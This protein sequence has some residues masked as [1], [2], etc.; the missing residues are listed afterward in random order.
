M[1]NIMKVK[2][3]F[4]YTVA[5]WLLVSLTLSSCSQNIAKQNSVKTGIIDANNPYI[6]YI[7]RFD[8]RN[9]KKVAFDWPG[10]YIYAKFQG[11]SCALRLKD[12]TNEYSI[13]IDN[14]APKLLTTGKKDVYK[15]ASGLSDSVAH[16]IMIQKRTEAFVG[17][18]VFMGFILD[19]GDS[20]LPPG[21]RPVRRIEFIG[22]SMTCGYGVLGSSPACHFSK[23]TED[24]GMSY[25][26][27]VARKLHADYHLVS[28][29]GKGV[30]RNYGDKNKTSLHP[31]P[32]LYDRTCWC[33]STLKWNFKSWVPQ[34]VV[35][36]L[37]TNDFSTHP[38]P[39]KDVFQ[40]AYNKLINRVRSL[41]PDVTIF[42]VSGP[43]IG[44]PC[45]DYINEVVKEQQKREGRVKDVFFIPVPRSDMNA[46]DWGCD[47]H[48]NIHGADVIS[49]VIVPA[50]KLRMN[51]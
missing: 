20:L 39:D 11:T 46:N 12:S 13:I 15:V 32:S 24:A 23:Q 7:G 40:A 4:L 8:F 28:Y 19:K 49:D 22:N 30:V 38:Y 35:I 42:C 10:V 37:G 45:T 50:I 1:K 17:K 36:N 16:T 29:S 3:R 44:N 27:M 2:L 26:A 21:K 33:D 18:G 14:H 34:T 47:S 31:M 5:T 9:P 41:Y 25:A 43:M 48:P 6:Q 51:W